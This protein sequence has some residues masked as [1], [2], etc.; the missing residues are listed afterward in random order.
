MS[1]HL[2]LSTNALAKAMASTTNADIKSYLALLI[3]HPM[4]PAQ[5][6]DLHRTFQH[7]HADTPADR[8]FKHLLLPVLSQTKNA[9]HRMAERE[10]QEARAK[11]NHT[12]LVDRMHSS[13]PIPES[14]LAR[15]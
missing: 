3:G 11:R 8:E 2:Y 15:M 12:R 5:F 13:K 14:W 9:A 1:Q 10:E 4:T 7:A 6:F